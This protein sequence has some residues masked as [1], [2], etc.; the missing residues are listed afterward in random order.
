AA[1]NVNIDTLTPNPAVIS[2]GNAFT[3][4][5]LVGQL[6]QGQLTISNGG[7]LTSVQ[8]RIGNNL[9]V[10]GAVTVSGAGSTWNSGFDFLIG[11]DGSGSLTVADGGT[12]NSTGRSRMG[13][14]AGA[15]GDVTV[16]GAGSIWN[17]DGDLVIGTSGDGELAIEDGGA[18]TTGS[19]V[20]GSSEDSLGSAAVAGAGSSWNTGSLIVGQFGNGA[21]R[22][23]D[24]GTLSS[25]FTV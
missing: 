7:T 16:T 24:G 18:V 23:S 25:T 3:N 5:L 1:D 2:G 6:G 9:G 4:W 14:S 8:S 15:Q 10:A 22:V 19:V 12:V 11:V 17:H 20:L 13:F 21:V